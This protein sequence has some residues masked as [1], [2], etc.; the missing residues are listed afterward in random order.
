MLTYAHIVTNSTMQVLNS[1]EIYGYILGTAFIGLGLF[2]LVS[3]ER[4][5]HNFGVPLPT[6]NP[7]NTVKS[8]AS[9]GQEQP[10]SPENAGNAYVFS[11]AGRDAVIGAMFVY[12]QWRQDQAGMAA[13]VGL[14]SIGA[15]AD[16]YDV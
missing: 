11:R 1:P 9:K 6:Y 16:G 7:A 10:E 5:R 3:L 15:V 4:T 2:P 8:S 14:L 12:L 13:L